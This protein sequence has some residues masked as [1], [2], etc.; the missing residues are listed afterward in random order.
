MN[1]VSDKNPRDDIGWTPLHEAAQEGHSKICELITNNIEEKN[2][3]DDNGATPSDLWR[4][5]SA[6]VLEMFED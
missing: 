3:S 1:E 6:R 2:P 5:Q 4:E